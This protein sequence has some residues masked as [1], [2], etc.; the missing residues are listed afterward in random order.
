[1]HRLRSRQ[2]Q[3]GE[4]GFDLAFEAGLNPGPDGHGFA[5]AANMVPLWAQ[6]Q[7]LHFPE[8]LL[9]IRQLVLQ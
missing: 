3:L 9:S 5:H 4:D 6:D 2:A 8:V 1:M 7:S